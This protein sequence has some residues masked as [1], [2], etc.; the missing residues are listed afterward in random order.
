MRFGKGYHKFEF[1]LNNLAFSTDSEWWKRAKDFIDMIHA[2]LNDVFK[3][4]YKL[5]ADE[6]MFAWYG[7]GNYNTMPKEC[8]LSFN[9]K[10]NPGES[11]VKPKL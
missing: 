9:L 8:K 4:G 10:E 5:C 1:I 3:P 2:K 6:S 7:G 11:V